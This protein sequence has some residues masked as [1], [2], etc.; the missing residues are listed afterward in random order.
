[1]ILK[2]LKKDIR[3]NKAITIALCLFITLASMLIAGAFSIVADMLGAMDDFYEKAKPLHYMQMVTG[4]VDQK[5]IDGFSSKHELVTAQQTLEL[6]DIDNN[7]IYYGDNPEPYADS[8]MENSFVTQS[9]HFDFLLDENNNIVSVE[10]GE[11]AVP[12]YAINA[13]SLK[14]GDAV[15]VKHGNFE[16]RF[17]VVCFIRDS[18]MN[19]SLVS[20]KR[21][22]IS[23]E[24]YILLKENMG[25]VEYLIEFQLTGQSKTGEFESDYLA[26]GLPSGIAITYSVIQLM[27]AMT[28]GL[29]V[30]VLLLAS[31][32]LI[33]IAVMCLRFTIL[34][35]LEEEYR[36]IGVMKAIGLA[37][38]LIEKL[39][40]YKYYLLGAVS[41]FVGFL[42]SLLFSSLFTQ[43]VSQ[44][45]GKAE[46]SIWTFVLPLAGAIAVFLVIILSC[47]LVLRKLRKVSVV[48]A[49]RGTTA[50]ARQG[51]RSFP[52]H[53]NGLH[54]INISLGMRDV[55]NR[56]RNYKT[57]IIVFTLCVFLII[58]PINFLNTLRSPDFIGYTGIGICDAVITLR[59]S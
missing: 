15:T 38:K 54:N 41:C 28:G 4:A 16:M 36:E 18:Q 9:P 37:P 42:L 51:G 39:Y 19:A 43:S 35:V 32:L 20:S 30:V 45:M 29:A 49:I 21:F 26:A 23:D 56:L 55:I 31:I 52:V 50:A 48:E 10:P 40:K 13:Y 57:P 17:T 6:L 27:N 14:V 25:E 1:M 2:M 33:A 5:S 46:T 58:V 8:V 22:L 34:A 11:I 24:D 47:S 44:Y 7:Y 3:Q 59:Y 53:K 12:I